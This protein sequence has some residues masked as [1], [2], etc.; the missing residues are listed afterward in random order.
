MKKILTILIIFSTHVAFCQD[1]YLVQN[2]RLFDGAQVL[3]RTDVLISNGV[4]K[5]IGEIGDEFDGAIIDGTDK[6]IIPGMVNCHV[7][8]WLPYHLENALE[9]GVFAVLDMHTSIHP[10]SLKKLKLHDGYARFLSTGYAATVPGGHGTQYG[11][12]VPTINE[13]RSPEQFVNESVSRGSD[14]IKIIYEPRRRT[15]SL[16]QVD[17]LIKASHSNDLM[18]VAHISTY[19]DAQKIVD[20]GIDG[21]VHIWNDINLDNDFLE[22]LLSNEVF[23]VPTL[24]VKEAVLKYYEE[25]GIK[26]TSVAPIG[27]TFSELLKLH[28]AGVPILAGTDPPNLGLDYGSSLHNELKLFVEAGLSPLEAIRTATSIPNK[29]FDL[30]DIG[31]V[32]EGRVANFNLI[33]GNPLENIDEISRIH[34]IWAGGKKIK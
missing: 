4:V 2:V 14:Y 22:Q 17:G 12:S 24:T 3:E 25:N 34:S 23:I 30:E 31:I 1:R 16:D 29:I 21:L 9:A 18:A 6:T 27:E 11:Y 10:D 13:D 15:L 26:N 5:K 20:L 33:D 19:G 28:D 8:A 7:H 32:G